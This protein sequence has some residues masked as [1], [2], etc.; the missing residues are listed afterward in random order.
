MDRPIDNLTAHQ[1]AVLSEVTQ[2]QRRSGTAKV[3]R[4]RMRELGICINASLAIATESPRR[5]RPPRVEHGPPVP[6]KRHGKCQRCVDIHAKSRDRWK[7]PPT[8]DDP[9]L[10]AHRAEAA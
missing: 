4:A 10:V 3:R 6:G 7:D 1:R 2:R 8:A 9:E 5:T